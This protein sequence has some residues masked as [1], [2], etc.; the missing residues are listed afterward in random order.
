MVDL[1]ANFWSPAFGNFVRTIAARPD[2][3]GLAS[4]PLGVAVSVAEAE[5]GGGGGL[6]GLVL[7]EILKDVIAQEPASAR[8]ARAPGEADRAEIIERL[9]RPLWAPPGVGPRRPRL[10]RPARV[11]GPARSRG[12]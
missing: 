1:H 9:H 12:S 7:A 8:I 2:P 4:S 11:S 6:M 5:G 10:W 3:R